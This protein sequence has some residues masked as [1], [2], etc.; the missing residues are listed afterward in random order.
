MKKLFTIIFIIGI[1]TVVL[2]Q[3]FNGRFSSSVY[4]F[5][6]Y[7][8]T[9]SPNT[10]LRSY[11]MLNLNINQGNVSLRTYMNLE[12]D[13]SGVKMFD[14]PMLRFYNLYLEVR[15]LFDIA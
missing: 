3:S 14:D 8:S 11:Q 13:L 4:S 12:G 9:S 10:Y 6:T 2:P 7:D 1:S 5:Q 15:D